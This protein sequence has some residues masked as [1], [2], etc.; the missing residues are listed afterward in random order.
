MK[1]VNARFPWLTTGEG[2]FFFADLVLSILLA[3]FQKGLEKIVIERKKESMRQCG[4][5]SLGGGIDSRE[6][7]DL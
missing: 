6:K 1:I 7:I 5:E 4:A 2:S 3:H